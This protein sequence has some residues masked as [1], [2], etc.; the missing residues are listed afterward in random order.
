MPIAGTADKASKLISNTAHTY[1]SGRH[2]KWLILEG[3]WK[4]QFITS[5]SADGKLCKH[6]GQDIKP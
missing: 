1:T 4:G 6:G 2:Q 3:H 5:P